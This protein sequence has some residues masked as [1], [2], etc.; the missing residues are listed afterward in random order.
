MKNNIKFWQASDYIIKFYKQRI[1]AR[2]IKLAILTRAWDIQFHNITQNNIL[3]KTKAKKT[4]KLMKKIFAIP[5]DL[6][7]KVMMLHF[8]FSEI[9]LR[10]SFLYQTANKIE[11]NE[12]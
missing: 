1:E 5:N 9:R 10:L 2:K 4:S 11:R 3:G 12:E 7:D 6:R 8:K